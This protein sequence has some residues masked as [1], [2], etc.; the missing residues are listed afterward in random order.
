MKFTHCSHDIR[1]YATILLITDNNPCTSASFYFN[2][3][4]Y[5]IDFAFS[6]LCLR[7]HR[8][9]HGIGAEKHIFSKLQNHL[10]LST[11]LIS[12]FID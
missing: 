8:D 5:I 9:R 10:Y 3:I 7:S 6:P 2:F 12:Q 1:F 11:F 4:I